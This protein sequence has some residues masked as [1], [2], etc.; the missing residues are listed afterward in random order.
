MDIT[1]CNS[2]KRAKM[3][4]KRGRKRGREEGCIQ[5]VEVFFLTVA[6]LANIVMIKTYF[7]W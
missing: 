7:I 5:H 3:G 1:V 4:K 2:R 6:T